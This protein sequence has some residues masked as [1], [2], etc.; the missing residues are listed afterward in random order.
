[1]R[2]PVIAG[3]WKMYKTQEEA[4]AFFAALKPLVASSTHCEIVD[5][6]RRSRRWRHRWPP[7][8][9]RPSPSPRRTCTGPREGAF[10]GEVSPQMLVEAGCRAVIIA[11]S[12]RRQFFGETDET[13]NKKVKA[14]LA[15]GLTPIFCVG[16]T[17]AER[18]AGSMRAVL[19]RQFRGRPGR[20]DRCG[21]LTYHRGL[22]AGV[23]HWNRP[24]GDAGN[25]CRGAPVSARTGGIGVQA[26]RRRRACESSTAAASNPIT[27][28]A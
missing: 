11:H 21:V 26:G 25:G 2:K 27:S 9:D 28:R 23:G 1:M 3:N 8:R 18:E 10:T 20:V 19:E 24:Y 15:A 7:R 14:A 6:R 17:L 12:E 16:E 5:R 13:A 4:R 22:R